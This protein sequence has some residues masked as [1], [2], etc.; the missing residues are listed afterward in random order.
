MEFE[1]Q[2]GIQCITLEFNVLLW[3]VM[4]YRQLK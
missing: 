3:K 2:I 1:V 4:C